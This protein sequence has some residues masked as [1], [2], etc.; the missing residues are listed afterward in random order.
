MAADDLT[1]PPGRGRPK[2]LQLDEAILEAAGAILAEHGYAGFSF[3]AVAK[4]SGTTRPAIYRR[5]KRR[6]DL[7]LAALDHVMHVHPAPGEERPWVDAGDDMDDQALLAMLRHMVAN[8]VRILSDPR[9]NAVAI[10]VSAATYGDPE[11]RDIVQ[12]HHYDRRK[13][14]EDLMRLAQARGLLRDDVSL[15]DQLHILVGAVQ[16]RATM[17]QE[18]ITE[19]YANQVLRVLL[20]PD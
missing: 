19:A 10:S 18:P 6:E 16:Y 3:E 12:T 14:L 17:L 1:A 9:A 11:V 15:D 4:A 8:L 13:P 5:W 20:R 2:S 7:L